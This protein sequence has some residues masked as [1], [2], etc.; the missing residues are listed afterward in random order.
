MVGVGAA[1]Y[2]GRVVLEFSGELWFWRGPSPFHFVTVGPDECGE[3]AAVAPRVS[4]GWGV[5][6]VAAQIGATRWTTSLLPKD[7]RYLVPVKDAIRKAEKLDLGDLVPIRLTI[8][9]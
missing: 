3:L 7:G 2:P 5:I 4:Y 6:P 8:E 1:S 9:V